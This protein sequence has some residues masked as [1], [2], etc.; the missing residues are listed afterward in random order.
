MSCFA[1][2]PYLQAGAFKNEALAINFKQHVAKFTPLTVE[3]LQNDQLVE[4]L[5]YVIIT[6][7]KTQE[8]AKI[9]QQHLASKGLKT[10]IKTSQDLTDNKR[11]Y[12][13]TEN[14]QI[15]AI[16]VDSA[17]E[18]LERAIRNPEYVLRNWI[19]MPIAEN[20]STKKVIKLSLKDAILLTLRYNPNIQSNELDRIIQRY[21]LRQTQ[22][23]LELQY[24]LTGSVGI[25]KSTTLGITTDAQTYVISPE[26]NL[27]T[28][29]GTEY[30]LKLDNNYLNTDT[31]NPALSFDIKQPLLRGFGP[32]VNLKNLKDALDDNFTNKL[33]LKQSI[34]DQITTVITN[35]RSL[36]TTGNNLVSQRN[37]IKEAIRTFE[38]NK[39]KI[40]A[41][42]LEPT[43]NVQQSY[44][45]K[46]LRISLVQSENSFKNQVQ[47]LL[48]SIGL[49]PNMNIQVPT[50]VD[51]GKIVIPD[52]EETIAYALKHNTEYI[53]QLVTVKKDKRE[54]D[55]AVNNQMWQLDLDASITSG[56][57]SGIGTSSH[58]SSL[59]NGSNV[60]KSVNLSLTIPIDD[61]SI[62]SDLINAKVQLEKDRIQ[63]VAQKR[64]LITEIK[65][66][67]ANI[68][69]N[70][71]QYEL[72]KEQLD[73][74]RQSYELE[75]KKQ[76]AG[77]ATSLDVTNTQ[78]QLLSAENSLISAKVD[79]LN[80]LSTLQATLATTLD[81][82]D[83]KLRY[84]G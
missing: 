80:E 22:N 79:Y 37:Q 54:Y 39:L 64:Q 32:T 9:E 69:A 13:W 3:I 84:T 25:D 35:Y 43:G 65:Q 73:Y 4:C 10:I 53:Q 42:Q 38:N 23:E 40:K 72:A 48:Q 66:T 76:Q 82:W 29:Y 5:Y 20:V 14:P 26:A 2:T 63:L 61:L 8:Q 44:Q 24:A 59:F 34:I 45:V 56:S 58:F 27:K 47:T 33:Q 49:D 21:S 83:I 68:K 6:G 1:A 67:L 60:S 28:A 15:E 36:I 50:D 55:L 7:L 16:R 31:F 74:A 17:R 70:A 57:G 11:I 46:S 41:G 18:H 78:D 77:I 75:K 71:Q 51:I 12:K 52:L 30:S 62:R 19:S 81:E